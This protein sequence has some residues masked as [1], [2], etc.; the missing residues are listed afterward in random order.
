MSTTSVLRPIMRGVLK[1]NRSHQTLPVFLLPSLIAPV[2]QASSFSSTPSTLYPRDMNRNRGVSSTRRSGLRQPLSVS[3]TELPKPVLDS[4]KRSKVE[5]DPDHGLWQFFHSKEKPM[6][7]PEEESAHGRAWC[8][9][10]LRGKSWEDL[11]ALWWI[12][13][14]ERNVIATEKR[15]RAR[16]EAGYGQ[17]ESEARDKCVRWTQRAIKQVLTERYYS[18][19]EAEIIAQQ[20]PEI[21]LSGS[22]PLYTPMEYEQDY[23]ALESPGE[24]AELMEEREP[25]QTIEPDFKPDHPREE[26]KLEQKTTPSPNA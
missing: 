15:E 12:C 21:D 26:V 14:K 18:W 25:E 24:D 6:N 19:R 1:S 11:H 3:K 8:P 10:E 5:V 7:T 16:L 17:S 9:E 4:K 22:G 23:E 2:Q 20:D 13:A